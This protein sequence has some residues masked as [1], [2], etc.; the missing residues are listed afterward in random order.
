MLAPTSEIQTWLT[1]EEEPKKHICVVH[2][3]VSAVIANVADCKVWILF[4]IY[5][6]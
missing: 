2:I 3:Y 6:A 4:I 5:V 1:R